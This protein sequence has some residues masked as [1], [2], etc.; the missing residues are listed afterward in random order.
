MT[1]TWNVGAWELSWLA[2]RTSWGVGV[3]VGGSWPWFFIALVIGPREF[4]V[5]IDRALS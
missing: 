5:S 2:Q 1:R 4:E 3:H